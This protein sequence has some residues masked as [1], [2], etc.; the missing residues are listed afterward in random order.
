MSEPFYFPEGDSSILECPRSRGTH[1]QGEGMR[2]P[3]REKRPPGATKSRFDRIPLQTRESRRMTY[4]EGAPKGFYNTAGVRASV[5]PVREQ[6]GPRFSM[7]GALCFGR[8][9]ASS[10]GIV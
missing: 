2:L 10:S 5:P 3:V 7:N 4:P 8:S 9:S 1:Q 6:V